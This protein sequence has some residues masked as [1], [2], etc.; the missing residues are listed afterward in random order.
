MS[1]QQP[2]T[3]VE[4]APP[5]SSHEE[6]PRFGRAEILAAAAVVVVLTA[7]FIAF[8]TTT[9]CDEQATEAGAVLTVCRHLQATDPPVVAFGIVI[10]V[11]LSRYFDVSVFGVSLKARLAHVEERVASVEKD[12]ES[13]KETAD[14]FGEAHRKQRKEAPSP[15]S[16]P[17]PPAVPPA[18]AA[19]AADYDKL[20]ATM[21]A[22]TER[23]QKMTDIVHRMSDALKSIQTFDAAFHLRQEDRGLRLAAY[24]YLYDNPRRELVPALVDAVLLEDKPFGEYWGY[25]ALN[26]QLEQYPNLLDRGTRARLDRRLGEL[27]PGTDRAIELERALS[28]S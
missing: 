17:A 26:R 9:I 24:A 15:L 7:G 16:S 2:S 4:S 22:S 21:R 28:Q 3:G 27:G 18:I 8:F 11:L 13:L 19:L 14:D 20:R 12:A 6:R 5:G 10:A 25:R 23:T 1:K